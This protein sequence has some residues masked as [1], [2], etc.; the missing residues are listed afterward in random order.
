V[1]QDSKIFGSIVFAPV[2][3]VF[4]KKESALISSAM[5]GKEVNTEKGLTSK[6]I[7]HRDLP[8]CAVGDGHWFFTQRP[9]SHPLRLML[10]S[11]KSENQKQTLCPE[12]RIALPVPG[13]QTEKYSRLLWAHA[14]SSP[15]PPAWSMKCYGSG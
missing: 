7:Q 8:G 11:R 12:S 13:P 6:N 3:V 10:F 4:T 14:F 15:V 5:A 1:A 2:A 9:Q